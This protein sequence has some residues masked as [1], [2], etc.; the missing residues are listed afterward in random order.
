MGKIAEAV[1]LG[2][3][4][5]L[6]PPVFA[7][8]MQQHTSDYRLSQCWNRVVVIRDRMRPGI[9]KMFSTGR[10]I[11]VYVTRELMLNA[12]A[13]GTAIVFSPTMCEALPEDDQLALVVGHEIAHNLL[14]HYEE[15]L[16]GQLAG[17]V[18][19]AILTG[20]TGVYLGGAGTTIG[21]IAFSKDREREA[22]Y[23]GLYLAAYAGYDISDAPELWRTLAHE[24]GGGSGGL[25]HPSFPERSARAMLVVV[26]VAHKERDG[27]PL[28]P[29]APPKALEPTLSPPVGAPD[30]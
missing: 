9:R 14:G 1:T 2:A 27:K 28:L 7:G 24:S 10:N 18:A 12:Y 23:Y 6:T 8:H 19:E 26:E 16:T 20:V 3:A 17:S 30:K 5:V 15:M 21:T 4:L 22:D 29:D 13:D 25:T 11:P